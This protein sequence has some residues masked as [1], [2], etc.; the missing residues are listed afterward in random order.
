MDTYYGPDIT[1]IF[2]PGLP[3]AMD[4]ARGPSFFPSCQEVPGIAPGIVGVN[5]QRRANAIATITIPSSL[6]F[7][8]SLA[9][10]W[11][12]VDSLFERFCNGWDRSLD[13]GAATPKSAASR[14]SEL[15]KT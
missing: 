13:A 12:E 1:N 5:A 15:G 9:M 6:A 10:A 14:R 11:Q 4:T 7:V 8:P 2:A 3:D